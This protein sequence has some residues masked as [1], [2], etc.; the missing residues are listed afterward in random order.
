MRRKK[1][2]W[3]N[4]DRILDESWEMLKR[5]A[6]HFNDPFHRAVLGTVGEHG[7][8][9]RLVILRE[10]IVVERIL[11]C[12]TD[13]RAS[14]AQEIKK[15]DIVSWLFYHPKKKIQL[16]IAGRAT[17]HAKDSIADEQWAAT[18]VASRF[19]YGTTESPGTPINAPSSGLPDFLLNKVPSVMQSEHLRK[20][21]M[22]ISCRVDSMD[23][24]KLSTLG[25][26]RAYF[27][28]YENRLEATWLVP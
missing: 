24:L 8:S 19:N 18:G 27:H 17:L 26:R 16:R 28:W 10:V 15:S 22:A 4:L 1:G 20:N 6:T 14:K 7:S 12:H 2:K 9:L 13:A 21:F 25:H 23:W 5:G 11:I 3:D